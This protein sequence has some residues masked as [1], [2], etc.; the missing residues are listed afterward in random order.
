M[1]TVFGI[2]NCDTI[3]KA[4]RWLDGHG[5]AYKFHD[6]KKQGVKGDIIEKAFELYGWE[7]VI[8]RKGM[9]WRQLPDEMKNTMNAETALSLAMEKPSVIKRPILAN[10][11]RLLI[12]FDADQY[13]TELL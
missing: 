11:D 6:Y 2:K 8:N 7:T 1:L 3:K 12:G 5:V 9:T 10:G 13:A 4:F